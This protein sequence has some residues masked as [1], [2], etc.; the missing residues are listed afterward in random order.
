MSVDSLVNQFNSTSISGGNTNNSD[1]VEFESDEVKIT[2]VAKSIGKGSLHVRV[3]PM[4]SGKTSWLLSQCTN[5]ADLG[6]NV[7]IV[8]S[9]LDERSN[10]TSIGIISS[11][12]SGFANISDKLGQVKVSNLKEVDISGF[13]VIGIDECQFYDD[14][15]DVVFEWIEYNNIHVYA[16]GLD[17]DSRKQPFGQTLR[18]VPIS[19]S[20]EKVTARCTFCMAELKNS[21]CYHGNI[22]TLQ[23]PFTLFRGQKHT[24]IHVGGLDNYI[25]VCRYHHNI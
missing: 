3:G 19:D 20:F 21:G 25:P 7:L 22:M 17:G 12:S 14:L 4:C 9:N 24:Q 18:L 11:H 15:Y 8:S 2:N 16:A 13:D 6:Y 10:T 23:A 1:S 5:F